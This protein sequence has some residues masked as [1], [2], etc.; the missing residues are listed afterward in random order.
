MRICYLASARSIH[1]AK[2][3]NYFSGNGH[4][5]Q[6]LSF[7]ADNDLDPSVRV[8]R[9]GKPW[10]LRAHYFSYGGTVRRI[11]KEI[12]P[13]ILHAHYA[14]GYATLGRLA[15]FHPYVVSVWGS[16]IFD[17]PKKSPF[18]RKIVVANLNSADRICSTSQVMADEIRLCCQRGINLTPFG[19]D[20]QE[21]RPRDHSGSRE[22]FVV[23]IVKA[24]EP[25]YGIE[26]LVRGFSILLKNSTKARKLRLIIAGEGSQ[27]NFLQRLARDLNIEARTTFLGFVPHETVPEILSQFSVFVA[28]SIME[29]ETFGV[30]VVEAS[31]SGL[32]VVVSRIGGLP[33]VVKDR[34]TGILVQPRDPVAIANALGELLENEELRATFGANGRKFILEN[35]EWTEN[36]SRMERIYEGLLTQRP[37][38]AISLAASA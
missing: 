35:Y 7:E 14:S 22:E 21:F 3:A 8:L 32:P 31:A 30:A 5:V 4:E 27:R 11:L 36:A 38:D 17:F 26:Y 24:L 28:P 9:L 33:E 25:K 20:C 13:D 12:Q 23:G 2:W 29:S 34:V 15:S 19:V 6:I 10:P 18:H 16:D 1:T 37:P